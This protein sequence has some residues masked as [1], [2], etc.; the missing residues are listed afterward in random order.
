[1][2]AGVQKG[3]TIFLFKSCFK[4]DEGPFTLRPNVKNQLRQLTQEVVERRE[5][6]TA[7]GAADPW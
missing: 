3:S 5:S 2:L 4:E 6:G 1:M 7:R